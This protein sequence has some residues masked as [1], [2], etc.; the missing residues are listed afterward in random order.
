MPSLS[1]S[2]HLAFWATRCNP[3]SRLLMLT[4]HAR[5]LCGLMVELWGTK[6]VG[7]MVGWQKSGGHQLDENHIECVVTSVAPVEASLLALEE[8]C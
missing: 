2:P 7:Q 8:D 5:S 4:R 6:I 1:T 3:R